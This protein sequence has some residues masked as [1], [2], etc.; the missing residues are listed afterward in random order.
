L[1]T[2]SAPADIIDCANWVG[3][4]SRAATGA[5][6]QI[7]SPYFGRAVG[8]FRDSTA[9]DI[10]AAVAE[11]ER[12]FVTWRSLP[13]RER[14][15]ILGSY[16]RALADSAAELS[17]LV[18]LESGKTQAEARAGLSRGLEVLDFATSVNNLDVGQSLEV[19]RGVRCETRREPL[20]VVAG[21]TPFNFPAMV[22]LW[23]APLA[24]VSGNAFILQPSD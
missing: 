8:S 4:R 2:I 1:S 12:G 6:R 11:A 17:Y 19:S 20:G 13:L 21:I 16:R 7:I 24:M 23:M 14:A 9:A 15:A 22:P 18:A 3:G 10:D 5:Q